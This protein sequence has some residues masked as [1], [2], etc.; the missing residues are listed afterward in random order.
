MAQ[1]PE[2]VK[3]VS[4]FQLYRFAGKTEKVLV[5]LGVIVS[6]AVGVCNPLMN[7]F[8]GR[9]LGEFKP[10]RS[11]KD[12]LDEVSDTV[13]YIVYVGIAALVLSTLT[14][15]TWILAGERLG[16]NVRKKYLESLLKKEVSWFDLNKPQELPTKIVAL[17][18]K[19][20][21]GIGNK[22]GKVLTAVALFVASL[23]VAF[24]YG[25]QLALVMLG[26]SPIT[27]L[28]AYM[29]GVTSAMKAQ[30]ERQGYAKC[31]GYAEEALS[32][33]RTV[34]AFCA[35]IVEKN[36]YLA[37]LSSSQGSTI[38]NSALFGLAIGVTYF[39]MAILHGLGYFIGSFFI[40]HE[41]RNHTFD[42]A[43]DCGAI[44]TTLYCS[45]TSIFYFGT[46][47][48]QMQ[49]VT[50]A[51]IA[52]HEI[53]EVIDSVSDQKTNKPTKQIPLDQFKGRIEFHN[54]TF[55][56]PGKLEVS[57]LKNF[58][59]VFEAGTMT[60]ICG[61]TGSGKSTIIQLIAVSYTHLTLPTNRE[62]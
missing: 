8:M 1:N 25:W 15:W 62:V 61:E 49:S 26:L 4:V 60:G 14:D 3:K 6:V 52:A 13:L 51:Q 17:I 16:V 43:Y 59:A 27:F 2:E 31:G 47:S 36:K 58:S 29:A 28:V 53:Y 41:V 56:Y 19:Y 42:K 39:S 46:I 11:S 44:I 40:Q 20:Q 7:V 35:E 12:V 37:E 34:Y 18:S 30:A 48:L 57:V 9:T 32:A 22:P 50:E 54:V 10:D 24:L 38:K 45:L 23:I 55:Q 21:R 5:V 33:I